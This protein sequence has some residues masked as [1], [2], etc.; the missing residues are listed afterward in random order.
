MENNNSLF[1]ILPGFQTM[2]GCPIRS[3]I[4]GSPSPIPGSPSPIQ[5]WP[6]MNAQQVPDQA[7]PTVMAGPGQQMGVPVRMPCQTLPGGI[8][9][10]QEIPVT[11][12]VRHQHGGPVQ[13]PPVQQPP[14]QQP[15]VQPPAQQVVCHVY[16][17]VKLAFY[18]IFDH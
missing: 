8:P 7:P 5:M 3:P 16:S 9:C 11:N 6:G 18:P 17:T 13:Q 4:Q 2:P 15:A 1:F 14:A 10:R 12:Q